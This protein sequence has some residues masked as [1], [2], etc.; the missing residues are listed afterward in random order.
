MALGAAAVGFAV[1]YPLAAERALAAWGPRAVG[2]GLCAL[3]LVSLPFAHGRGPVH[4]P[5]ALRAA[6]LVLPA[7]AAVRGQALALRLVPASIQAAVAVVFV[8]SLRGGGSLF[9]EVARRIEPHAPDFIG[10]YCRKAT[11]VFAALFALQGAG[12]GW[13]ALH[14]PASGW[15]F[16]SGVLVWV[17]VGL[18]FAV[19]WAVRKSWF[20]HYGDGP[21]DRV[22]RALLPPE[23]TPQ[24]RRSLEYV[25]RK[26]RELGMPPP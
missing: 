24:G 25:R 13:L 1:L 18:G 9:E 2:A 6:L 14:P 10:P 19:E 17:P 23:K 12:V 4:V 3:G 16:A 20:R 21:V 15:A 8:L 22:L 5:V 7:V 26:R 11:L